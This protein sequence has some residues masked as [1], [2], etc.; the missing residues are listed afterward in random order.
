VLDF[1]API[2]RRVQMVTIFLGIV[3]A[4]VTAVEIWIAFTQPLPVGIRLLLI[5]TPPLIAGLLVAIAWFSQ[6]GGY[7]LTRDTLEIQRR[8]RTK[9]FPLA[10]LNSAEVD[11]QAMAWSI[12]LFGND[13]L[14]AI[15]GRYRNRRLGS[16]RAFVSDPERLVVLRWPDHCVVVSPDRPEEFAA[17]AR[18][19][20]RLRR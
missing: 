9:L 2:G 12:Q 4:G 7:R 17:A 19:R 6:V 20:A 14:G 1:A 10:G 15:I 3:M 13:G 5:C 18:E 8:H 16:Y 11:P